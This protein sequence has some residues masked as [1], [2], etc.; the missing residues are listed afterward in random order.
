MF[1]L[2]GELPAMYTRSGMALR[3]PIGEWLEGGNIHEEGP[4]DSVLNDKG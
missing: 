2:A 1:N 3:P 4:V